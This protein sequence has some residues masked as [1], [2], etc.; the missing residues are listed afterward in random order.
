MEET[1]SPRSII[2]ELKERYSQQLHILRDGEDLCGR[3]SHCCGTRRGCVLFSGI[4]TRKS[5][6]HSLGFVMC[7]G[8][9]GYW[10]KLSKV[11]GELEGRQTHH[12]GFEVWAP[13]LC[14]AV[15]DFPVVIDAVRRVELR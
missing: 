12:E 15:A 13:P 7:A 11:E 8:T 5:F 10:A 9:N 2:V 14:K 3:V 4:W 6:L 1:D